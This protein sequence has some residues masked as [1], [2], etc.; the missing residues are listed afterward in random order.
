MRPAEHL[1]LDELR[2]LA[3][4]AVEL[5]ADSARLVPGALDVEAAD[6]LGGGLLAD[7][8]ALA[9]ALQLD[10]DAGRGELRALARVRTASARIPRR[11]CRTPASST[12]W[13]LERSC[14]RS[15][16]SVYISSFSRPWPAAVGC[17]RQER[18]PPRRGR[19]GRQ[20]WTAYQ[21]PPNVGAEQPP[22]GRSRPRAR[23]FPG[24]LVS[25]SPMRGAPIIPRARY[26][27][28]T[29]Y[30]LYKYIMIFSRLCTRSTFSAIRSAGA[31]SSCSRPVSNRR[32][33]SPRSSGP[34][35]GS[36]SPR[37]PS[38]SASCARRGSRRCAPRAPVGSTPSTRSRCATSTPGST[39][40]AR[41]GPRTWTRS[42]PR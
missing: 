23:V 12:P 28:S 37:C 24:A 32:A 11:V 30:C 8:L 14:S 31:S 27:A 38:T 41:S 6:R 22:A 18:S 5:V 33:R 42:P 4:D 34:S 21:S 39:T 36:P 35:S 26:N 25:Q 9:V 20:T 1:E 29:G 19:L 40:S 7:R 3:R 15:P 2:V 10:L 17:D 13:W 16:F